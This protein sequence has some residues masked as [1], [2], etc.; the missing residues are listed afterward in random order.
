VRHQLE[1]ARLEVEALKVEQAADQV[2]AFH[3]ALCK[4]RAHEH[5][6]LMILCP[7][8][9]NTRTHTHTH[10]TSHTQTLKETYAH[11]QYF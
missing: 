4:P 5:K 6:S 3:I 1:S 8:H 9:T 10:A 11:T 2:R 7:V